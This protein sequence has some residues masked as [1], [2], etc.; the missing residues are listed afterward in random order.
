MKYLQVEAE[1]G[2]AVVASSSRSQAAVMVLAPGEATGGPDNKH[3]KSDQWLYV[4]SGEGK[5]TVA[6]RECELRRGT[7]LLIEAGEAHEITNSG[8]QALETL[9]VYAPPEY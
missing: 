2:F 5:A 1:E 8:R 3:T 4:I 7:L 6:E 9:N